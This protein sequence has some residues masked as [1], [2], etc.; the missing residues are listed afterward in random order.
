MFG[1]FCISGALV[2]G[3]ALGAAGMTILGPWAG[4]GQGAGHGATAGGHTGGV[5]GHGGGHTGAHGAGQG[6]HVR[7]IQFESA[8][9]S[10]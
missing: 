7:F 1:A 8:F 10:F 5:G 9:I 3:G 2:L 6:G 4:A